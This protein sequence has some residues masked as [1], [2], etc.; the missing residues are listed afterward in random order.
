MPR[1]IFKEE[2][3]ARAGRLSELST[4]LRGSSSWIRDFG[5]GAFKP[6]SNFAPDAASIFDIAM[7]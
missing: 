2:R 3:M 7:P 6:D 4:V 1:L 5:G